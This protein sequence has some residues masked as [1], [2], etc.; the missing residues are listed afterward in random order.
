[1]LSDS[2]NSYQTPP[3][4]GSSKW[5]QVQEVQ[6]SRGDGETSLSLRRKLSLSSLQSQPCVPLSG[7]PTQTLKWHGHQTKGKLIKVSWT[8]S[9]KS[10][11]ETGSTDSSKRRVWSLSPLEYALDVPKEEGEGSPNYYKWVPSDYVGKMLE[12]LANVDLGKPPSDEEEAQGRFGIGWVEEV[13]WA[14]AEAWQDFKDEEV[15]DLV[16]THNSPVPHCG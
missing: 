16:D 6:L 1:M 15:K 7:G 11:E 12:Q 10:L 5:D 2:D 14:E 9:S 13:S 4:A 3:L 8:H